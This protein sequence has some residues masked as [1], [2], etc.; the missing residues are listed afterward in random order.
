[1]EEQPNNIFILEHQVVHDQGSSAR[2]KHID[3]LVIH[4]TMTLTGRDPCDCCPLEVLG[5]VEDACATP[6]LPV[7]TPFTVPDGAASEVAGKL[8]P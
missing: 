1:V 6:L 3:R 2:T 8:P 5:L 7:L 4:A